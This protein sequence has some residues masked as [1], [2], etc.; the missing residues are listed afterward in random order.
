M[1]S[2]CEDKCVTL[3]HHPAVK[4]VAWSQRSSWDQRMLTNRIHL[5]LVGMQNRIFESLFG[6]HT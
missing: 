4:Y 3:F 6:S 5:F 1:L 2:D